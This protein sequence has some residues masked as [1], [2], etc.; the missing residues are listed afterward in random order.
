LTA[1]RSSATVRAITHDW[2]VYARRA[3]KL[4]A[5]QHD[6]GDDGELF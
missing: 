4:N 1:F 3:N 5:R 2:R 6:E